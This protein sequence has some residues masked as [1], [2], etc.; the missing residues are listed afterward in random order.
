MKRNFNSSFTFI[1]GRPI[2]EPGS[3]GADGQ[4]AKAV[5]LSLLTV[6]LTAIQGIYEDEKNLPPTDKIARFNLATRI[7][8]TPLCEVSAEEV[9]ML[10]TLINKAYPSP[11][12]VAQAWQILDADYVEPAEAGGD[13]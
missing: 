3:V 9:S 13:V 12:I 4:P 5:P 6:A 1:D 10:K 7:Y 2:T 11:L 8:Q